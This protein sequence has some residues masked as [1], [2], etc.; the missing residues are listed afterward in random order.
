MPKY[1]KIVSPIRYQLTTSIQYTIN[2]TPCL[3]LSSCELPPFKST[4]HL[5]SVTPPSYTPSCKYYPPLSSNFPEPFLPSFSTRLFPI[6]TFLSASTPT[7]IRNLYYITSTITSILIDWKRQRSRG[8]CRYRFMIRPQN[9]QLLKELL[10]HTYLRSL[11]TLI[12][13]L[14]A[15]IHLCFECR[16]CRQQVNHHH[17][18]LPFFK[19][20]YFSWLQFTKR[21]R[22]LRIY[23]QKRYFRW[24]LL[25]KV[26]LF[27]DQSD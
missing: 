8:T 10:R 4:D 27:N 19:L 7:G 1:P 21:N 20:F 16:S 22:I 11:E 6:D 3:W 13:D 26:H 24:V 18:I 15:D 5:L 23:V 14:C 12:Y 17:K 2:N 9:R 25:D